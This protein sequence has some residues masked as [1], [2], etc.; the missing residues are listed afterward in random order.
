M[1]GMQPGTITPNYHTKTSNPRKVTLFQGIGGILD[2]GLSQRATNSTGEI[3]FSGVKVLLILRNYINIVLIQTL[4]RVSMSDIKEL[5][6]QILDD[7][8][9]T[10]NEHEEFMSAVYADG[11]VDEE[12]SE[13]ISRI[14]KL[15]QEGK[16]KIVN[17]ERDKAEIL[18]QQQIL[19]DLDKLDN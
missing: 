19:D 3:I 6:D 16:L 18:R 15:I 1:S 8:V 12:E 5:L 10:E 13:Q 4:N 2:H 17:T 14:F 7:G 9:M 11:V